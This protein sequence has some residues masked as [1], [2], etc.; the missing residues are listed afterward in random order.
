M[1]LAGYAFTLISVAFL[2]LF[3]CVDERGTGCLAKTKVLFWYRMPEMLKSIAHKICG[4]RFVRLIERVIRYVCNE[5]NP[6]V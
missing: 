6:F 4:D 1:I 2:Y 5:R 3:V